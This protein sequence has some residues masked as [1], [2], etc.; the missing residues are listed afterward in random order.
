MPSRVTQNETNIIRL[1]NRM[2]RVE[3][4]HFMAPVADRHLW[5]PRHH[6][7]EPLHTPVASL[8]KGS[9]LQAEGESDPEDL[10]D[11][12]TQF[13]AVME[14]KHRQE[15]EEFCALKDRQRAWSLQPIPH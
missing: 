9:M 11:T 10:D 4:D 5:D 8:D 1:K 6:A 7:S 3:N 13:A 2:A 14:E 12:V 15:F